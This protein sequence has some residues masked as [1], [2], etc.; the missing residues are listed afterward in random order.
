MITMAERKNIKNLDFPGETFMKLDD[1][2]PDF[3]RA[4]SAAYGRVRKYDN[5]PML[6]AWFEKKTGLHSPSLGSEVGGDPD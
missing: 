5:D 1:P 4:E 6:L 3:Q 2:E